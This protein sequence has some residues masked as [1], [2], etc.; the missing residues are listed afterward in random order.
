[1]AAWSDSTTK[2]D[3]NV[4]E[5]TMER[6]QWIWHWLVRHSSFVLIVVA[7]IA[8]ASWTVMAMSTRSG[9]GLTRADAI[10]APMPRPAATAD[11]GDAAWARSAAGGAE[12]QV[13]YRLQKRWEIADTLRRQAE[14]AWQA[15]EYRAA[16][17]FYRQN[18]AVT[19]GFPPLDAAQEQ[20][21]EIAD[22][23][24]REANTA[25]QAGDVRRAASL[26]RQSRAVLP[27]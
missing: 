22:R 25:W 3:V 27:W 4:K 19:P 20:R 26:Y 14:S 1:M 7:G 6:T 5:G 12:Q 9:G 24:Q 18:W 11:V 8:L 17:A 2:F 15:G 23:L 10:P 16:A 13:D 21:W